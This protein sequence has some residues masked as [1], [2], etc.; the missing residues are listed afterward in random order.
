MVA[1]ATPPILRD[2]E[3]IISSNKVALATLL[4]ELWLGEGLVLALTLAPV[5][6]LAI[7]RP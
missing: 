5:L 1:Q 7:A 2:L 6:A 3:R 4:L